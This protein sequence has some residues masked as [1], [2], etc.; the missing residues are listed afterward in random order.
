MLVVEHEGDVVGFAEARDD[1]SGDAVVRAFYTH[2]SV[3][4]LGAGRVLM[5]E[6]L[7]RLR[8]DGFAAARLRTADEN[9]RPQH[10]SE[11]DEVGYRIELTSRG[12]A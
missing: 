12:P 6:L 7:A 2:P 9:H 8:A 5:D 1:G 11:F 3:W 10:G 4:G